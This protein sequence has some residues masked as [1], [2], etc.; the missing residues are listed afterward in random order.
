MNKRINSVH[1]LVWK[2]EE[3]SISDDYNVDGQLEEKEIGTQFLSEKIPIIHCFVPSERIIEEKC[4]E[5]Q[6]KKKKKKYWKR[7]QQKHNSLIEKKLQHKS[8]WK[9]NEI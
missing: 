9:N 4:K 7:Y 2:I 8:E 6:K 3:K 5:L 1:F